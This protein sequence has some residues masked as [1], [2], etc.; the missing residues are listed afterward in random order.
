MIIFLNFDQLNGLSLTFGLFLSQALAL[1]QYFF[2]IFIQFNLKLVPLVTQ[3]PLV[4]QIP[5]VN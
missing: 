2:F 5:L 3:V 1:L 4:R